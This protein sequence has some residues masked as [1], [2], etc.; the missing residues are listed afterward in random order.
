MKKSKDRVVVKTNR[1]HTIVMTSH[2][3]KETSEGFKESVYGALEYVGV[4][5]NL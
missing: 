3:V 2:Y 4:F 5:D 1:G